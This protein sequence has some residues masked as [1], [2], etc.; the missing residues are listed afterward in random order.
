MYNWHLTLNDYLNSLKLWSWEFWDWN[1]FCE[2]TLVL[3]SFL[4][5]LK[6]FAICNKIE[7][8]D[9]KKISYMACF[10]SVLDCIFLKLSWLCV[11]TF[12][13]Y[14][15]ITFLRTVCLNKIGRK[16]SGVGN[17]SLLHKKGQTSVIKFCLHS[18]HCIEEKHI[19]WLIHVCFT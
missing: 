18:N 19:E 12:I 16:V 14:N 11:F 17:K 1:K 10:L 3:K 5:L 2:S 6:R 8:V 15:N 13:F 9:V 4:M 7:N